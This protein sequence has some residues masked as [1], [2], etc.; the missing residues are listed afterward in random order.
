MSFSIVLI[1]G[2]TELKA[3]VA[4]QDKTVSVP[5]LYIIHP[6]PARLTIT[7]TDDGETVSYNFKTSH[8]SPQ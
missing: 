4:W 6:A 2:L 5:F 3:Q 8:Y 7:L 1:F